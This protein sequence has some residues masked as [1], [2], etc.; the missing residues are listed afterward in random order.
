MIKV[1]NDFSFGTNIGCRLSSVKM[2]KKNFEPAGPLLS[3]RTF[4][5][6]KLKIFEFMTF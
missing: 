5:F 2:A 6:V 1:E 3:Y 4:F